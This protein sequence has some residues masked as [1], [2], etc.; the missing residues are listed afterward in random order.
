MVTSSGPHPASPRPASWGPHVLIVEDD[1]ATAA[2]IRAIVMRHG[3]GCSVTH[4][5]DG[6][7]AVRY[8]SGEA[9]F[10][11]REIHPDPDLVILDLGL[12]DV[13]GLD[14]L[15]W[16]DDYPDAPDTAVLVF[17]GTQDPQDAERAY[18]LGARA[19]LHKSA[20]PTQLIALVKDVIERWVPEARDGTHG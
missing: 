15:A 1:A 3:R 12:P 10:H 9:P 14:V 16:L 17:S 5:P 11:D 18:A 6:R 2:L 8:L 20:D 19:F 4:V 13:S 7:R